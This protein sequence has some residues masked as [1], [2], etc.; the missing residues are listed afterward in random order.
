MDGVADKSKMEE[1]HVKED[2]D[3]DGADLEVMTFTRRFPKFLS[4]YLPFFAQK[5]I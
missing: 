5:W 1:D 4:K 3:D 2:S